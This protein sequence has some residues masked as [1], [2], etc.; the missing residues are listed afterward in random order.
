MRKLGFFLALPLVGGLMG[1][2]LSD[3]AAAIEPG[4]FAP[5][6]QA[7][8][9]LTPVHGFFHDGRYCFRKKI[10]YCRAWRYAYGKRSCRSYGYRYKWHGCHGHRGSYY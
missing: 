1:S 8:M 10:R 5:V 4:A 2:T 3:R 9:T 6:P 7:N